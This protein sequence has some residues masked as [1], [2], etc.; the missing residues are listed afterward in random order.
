[1]STKK[2]VSNWRR[3]K[4]SKWPFVSS[5]PL[6]QRTPFLSC[7]WY[8]SSHQQKGW[9]PTYAFQT[10]N[11]PALWIPKPNIK[12]SFC[13]AKSCIISLTHPLPWVFTHSIALSL[14]PHITSLLSATQTQQMCSH[15]M[16]FICTLPSVLNANT[17]LLFFKCCLLTQISAKIIPL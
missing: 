2:V 3:R 16:D 12:S 4:K 5:P 7:A 13:A 9:W 17:K 15:F 11:S 8:M 6:P 10:M 1:M 14:C